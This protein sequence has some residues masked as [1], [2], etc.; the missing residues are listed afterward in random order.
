MPE[1]FVERFIDNNFIWNLLYL[2][3]SLFKSREH[4][5]QSILDSRRLSS[6]PTCDS[7][8][9]IFESVRIGDCYAIV[10]VYCW[11]I[12]GALIILFVEFIC[13]KF[14]HINQNERWGTE[15]NIQFRAH[16]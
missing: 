14:G 2:P 7:Q 3:F 1:R 10:L 6:K 5:L 12:G 4:G 9:A 15:R 11:G 13:K 8:A 16:Q